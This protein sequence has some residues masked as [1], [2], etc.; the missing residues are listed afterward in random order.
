M[1][2]FSTRLTTN[3]T[4]VL[5]GSDEYLYIRNGTRNVLEELTVGL[6]HYSKME[7]ISRW[8]K[9]EQRDKIAADMELGAGTVSAVVSDWKIEIGIPNADALRQFSTELRRL[10]ATPSQCVSGCRILSVLRKIRIDEE[11]LESF[12]SQITSH[13]R[14]LLNAH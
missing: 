10:G 13:L 1:T 6:P 2:K 5:D 7:I 4:R 14:C 8:L 3:L 11:N 9:G 12:A